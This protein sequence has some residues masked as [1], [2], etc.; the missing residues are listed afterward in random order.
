ME[1]EIATCRRSRV[2]HRSGFEADGGG[3]F[4]DT[5]DVAVYAIAE[6]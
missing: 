4:E 3:G 2:D 6:S 5:D 1:A